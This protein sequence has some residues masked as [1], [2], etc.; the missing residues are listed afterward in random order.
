M[1]KSN[2]ENSKRLNNLKLS[3]A[4]PLTCVGFCF[5]HQTAN[6]MFKSGFDFFKNLESSSTGTS[7]PNIRPLTSSTLTT[8]GGSSISSKGS[9]LPTQASSSLGTSPKT[10]TSITTSTKSTLSTS[11]SLSAKPKVSPSTSTKPVSSSSVDTHTYTSSMH[12][13]L[14]SSEDKNKPPSSGSQ[15]RLL[16]VELGDHV[17]A[18]IQLPS[19]TSQST[20]SSPQETD[21]SKILTSNLGSYVKNSVRSHLLT[22]FNQ[23]TSTGTDTKNS[24]ILNK[25]RGKVYSLSS[26]TFSTETSRQ[27]SNKNIS[28]NSKV[29]KDVENSANNF[30]KLMENLVTNNFEQ[31]VEHF[32]KS[33]ELGRL[34]SVDLIITSLRVSRS[35][36]EGVDTLTNKHLANSLR[37]FMKL[38]E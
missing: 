30:G 14:P 34:D 10:T 20:V 1:N 6:A 23:K 19:Y 37:T 2:L 35:S 27:L 22:T 16:I 15:A 11:S 33:V 7:N 8:K 17:Q 13:K 21:T 5:T 18:V 12:I 25:L 28:I 9:R 36:S 31:G 24:E 29:Q 38:Y 4:L 3:Y 32:N 26:Q